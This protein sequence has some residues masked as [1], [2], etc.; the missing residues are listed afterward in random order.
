MA[1]HYFKGACQISRI[2]PMYVSHLLHLYTSYLL[3]LKEKD[4]TREESDTSCDRNFKGWV[5]IGLQLFVTTSELPNFRSCCCCCSSSSSSSRRR[6]SSTSSS[7]SNCNTN[8]RRSTADCS[9]PTA[10]TA[11]QDDAEVANSETIGEQGDGVSLSKTKVS[12]LNQV[13]K[14]HISKKIDSPPN[15][16]WHIFPCFNVP[17]NPLFSPWT[18]TFPCLVFPFPQQ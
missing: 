6:S 16:L 17:D 10:A 5:L 7:N 9:P 12:R 1:L 18:I 13:G 3:W 15:Q 4:C 8:R 14:I 11:T 2:L